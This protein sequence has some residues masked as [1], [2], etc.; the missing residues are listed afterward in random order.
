MEL[1][2]RLAGQ[3]H[4]PR[5]ARCRRIAQVDLREQHARLGGGEDE[6]TRAAQQE[7]VLGALERQAAQRARRRAGDVEDPQHAARRDVEPAAV[8]LD[9]VGLVD[10]RLL[11][12]RARERLRV[13]DGRRRGGSRGD[14]HGH[15][16]RGHPGLG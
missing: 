4:R 12:V 2:G 15:A 10:A 16:G 11:D 9:E 13:C 7:L 6:Q 3:L 5:D 14:G 1:A 8:G